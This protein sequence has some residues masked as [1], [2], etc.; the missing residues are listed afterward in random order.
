MEGGPQVPE[1]RLYWEVDTLETVAQEKGKILSQIALNWLLGRME[2][3]LPI[4]E[5][6][7]SPN[8]VPGIFTH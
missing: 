4:I 7:I 1:E 8:H 6:Y 2:G 5:G 3:S